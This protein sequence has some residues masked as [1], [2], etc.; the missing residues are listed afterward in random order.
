MGFT[1]GILMKRNPLSLLKS[2]IAGTIVLLGLLGSTFSQTVDVHAKP[3]TDADIQLLRQD[4]QASKNQVI[5]N[6]MMFNEKEA[7]AFW[8]VYKEYAATQ[9]SIAQKRLD[10]ISDYARNLDKMTD[11][12]ARELTHRLFVV[13]DETQA[14]RKDFFPRFEKALGARRAAKFYEV[15]NRLTQMVNIQLASEI[16]LIP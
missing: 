2:T 4:L 13:E 14:A 16:P 6:T 1:E 11:D 5:N 10:I 9:H 12:K 8:P 15:D 3:I 7:A